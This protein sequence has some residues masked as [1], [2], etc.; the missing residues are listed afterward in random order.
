MSSLNADHERS[1]LVF[2]LVDLQS[3]QPRGHL[4][5]MTFLWT[6]PWAQLCSAVWAG[7]REVA[8]AGLTG[9]AGVLCLPV[10]IKV[11]LSSLWILEP[12]GTRTGP[13]PGPICLRTRGALLVSMSEYTQVNQN[14]M[15][16]F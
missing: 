3:A 5:C 15:Y 10:E 4:L 9:R 14:A 8:S 7:S 16:F 13:A 2:G 6:P 1:P 11:I 12:L